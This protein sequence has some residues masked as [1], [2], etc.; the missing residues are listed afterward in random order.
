[1]EI[2]KT[3]QASLENKRLMFV[4]IGFVLSLTVVLIAFESKSAVGRDRGVITP[5]DAQQFED[6]DVIPM[7]LDTP[8]EMPTVALPSLDEIIIVDDEVDVDDVLIETEDLADWA[9]NIEDY[10][11]E[12][13]EEP[14]IDEEIP[15]HLVEEEPTFQG[16]DAN[17][18]SMW[19]NQNIVYPEVCRM[20]N[21]SGRVMLQFTVDKNGR[22][23][24][25]KILREIDP[26]LAKEAVRVVS[27]SPKW[28]PGR[29]RGRA[30]NV[31]YTF[32]VQFQLK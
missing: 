7:P 26:D 10:R 11:T 21:V 18:F 24:N 16:G 17:S 30:V 28:E 8:P 31:T 6:D 14:E 13:E 20:N 27:M 25:V 22:L 9:V 19:V 2:K 4:E 5:P 23:G 12:V 15:F 1:M 29:Q 3:F 32:P